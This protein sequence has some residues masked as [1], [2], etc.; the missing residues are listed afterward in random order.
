MRSVVGDRCWLGLHS[1]GHFLSL[2]P[3]VQGH[4]ETALSHLPWG[5]GG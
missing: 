1:E 5:A 2:T 4:E 3:V